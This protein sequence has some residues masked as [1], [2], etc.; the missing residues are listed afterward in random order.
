MKR[1]ILRTKGAFGPK[2]IYTRSER[3]GGGHGE[4]SW[5]EEVWLETSD[6]TKCSMFE[7]KA[8]AMPLLNR[9]A[10]ENGPIGRRSVELV[11]ITIDIKFHEDEI[12]T[13]AKV[14]L[15]D[16][17]DKVSDTIRDV[18]RGS[19]IDI[20]SDVD[21]EDLSIIIE[22]TNKWQ[23]IIGDKQKAEFDAKVEAELI[24]S[25]AMKG[26]LKDGG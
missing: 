8:S 6:I 1:F 24:W 4:G 19:D 18:M 23:K 22:I 11:P 17:F 26:A 5:M 9:I 20:E 15:V 12:E 16:T 3:G 25:E 7:H 21:K 14:E 13:S 10:L 2:Y